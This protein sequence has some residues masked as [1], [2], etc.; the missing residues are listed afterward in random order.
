MLLEKLNS[1][2]N[3][4]FSSYVIL[5]CNFAGV[6]TNELSNQLKQKKMKKALFLLAV[7]SVF[8][9]CGP[10]STETPTATAT[11]TPVQTE[12]VTATP[13]ETPAVTPAK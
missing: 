12:T 8:A 7:A 13:T 5:F 11:E 9:A 3:H 1:K 2:K 6:K 4:F 10:K